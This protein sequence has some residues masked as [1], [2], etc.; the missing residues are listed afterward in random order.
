MKIRSVSWLLAV[1]A[2]VVNVS[3]RPAAQPA[4]TLVVGLVAEPVNLDPAQV[5]D[6]PVSATR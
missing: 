3:T 1:V 5:T 2:F 4:G 6:L